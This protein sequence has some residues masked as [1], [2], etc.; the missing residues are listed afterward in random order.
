MA[1]Q[2]DEFPET[3]YLLLATSKLS[4]FS[5]GHHISNANSDLKTLHCLAL[6]AEKV[7][8]KSC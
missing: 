3:Q 7:M 6:N 1:Q 8:P 2:V 5:E 4:N